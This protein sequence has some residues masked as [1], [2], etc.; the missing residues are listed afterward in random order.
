[1]KDNKISLGTFVAQIFVDTMATWKFISVIL[2]GCV[3]EMY[4]N[5][6]GWF[7]FDPTM[8]GLNTV[9]SLWAAVQG[10]II[11]INQNTADRKRDSLL[12]RILKLEKHILEMRESNDQAEKTS[13]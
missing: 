4:G 9:L 10:S 8:L 2:L 3:I 13:V 7:H 1:M 5:Q 6:R 12:R 11:M